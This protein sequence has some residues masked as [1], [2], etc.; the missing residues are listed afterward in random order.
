MV[1]IQGDGKLFWHRSFFCLSLPV[2]HSS[3]LWFLSLFG[4]VTDAIAGISHLV[5]N[6]NMVQTVA[7]EI[8][9]DVHAIV[10]DNWKRYRDQREEY[11]RLWGPDAAAA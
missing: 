11:E 5:E 1:Y 3:K 10:E 6:V 7:R 9:M 4:K 8:A 2:Q